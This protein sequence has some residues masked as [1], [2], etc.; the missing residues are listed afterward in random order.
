M[1]LLCIEKLGQNVLRDSGKIKFL[2]ENGRVSIEN[3][4]EKELKDWTI[5]INRQ[6]SQLIEKVFGE[7]GVVIFSFLEKPLSEIAPNFSNFDC[8]VKTNPDIYL[9]SKYFYK[10]FVDFFC[11]YYKNVNKKFV[12]DFYGKIGKIDL[13]ESDQQPKFS[14]NNRFNNC[15]IP[16]FVPRSIT[17]LLNKELYFLK[18]PERD[19]E[20]A[21]L[22][23]KNPNVSLQT[24]GPKEQIEVPLT[25]H[26]LSELINHFIRPYIPVL[27]SLRRA[28]NDSIDENFPPRFEHLGLKS[29]YWTL[30]SPIR[31]I[32]DS[33]ESQ[34]LKRISAIEGVIFGAVWPSMR[35]PCHVS[36]KEITQVVDDGTL[37]R[38]K[39]LFLET[40]EGNL[41]IGNITFCREIWTGKVR[42]QFAS[43][44]RYRFQ[45]GSNWKLFLCK[46]QIKLPFAASITSDLPPQDLTS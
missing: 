7:V 38:S 5:S 30:I 45:P 11:Y 18:P 2:F 3:C 37:K 8:L 36:L 4:N 27:S 1:A 22:V 44:S 42:P 28:I 15:Q 6:R 20:E 9:V 10:V 23:I 31:N 33:L 13:K 32:N 21:Q 26:N 16:F 12:L 34:S 24:N 39:S 19:G 17:V 46:D 35:L 29:S 40:R 14:S 25:F 43:I 41:Y